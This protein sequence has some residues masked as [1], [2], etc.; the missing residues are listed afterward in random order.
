MPQPHHWPSILLAALVPELASA[1]ALHVGGF[2]TLGLSC[3]SSDQADFVLNVQPAGPGRSGRCDPRLDSLLAVQVDAQLTPVLEFGLQLTSDYNAD[4]DFAPEP[5]VAQLRWHI[6][7]AATLRLGRTHNP[8]FLYSESRNVRYAMPWVRPPLEV[9]GL[10]PTYTF[11]GAEILSQG[12]WQG[13]HMEFQGSAAVADIDNPRANA[14]GTDEAELKQAA[15]GLT[16]DQADMLF[17]ASYV[18]GRVSYSTPDLDALFGALRSLGGAAGASLASDLD[19]DDSRYDLFALAARYETDRWLVLAE[20]GYRPIDDSFFRDMQGAYITV[21]RNIG[22]WMPYATLAQ[23]WTH[24][25]DSDPRAG[26]F[27]PLVDTVLAATRFD[28]RSLS[29]GL[30]RPVHANATLKLQL[31]WIKPDDASWGLYTNHGSDYDYA[32]PDADYLM[33]INLDFVF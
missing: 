28:S 6:S 9:Y 32:H 21:G 2:G 10:L 26:A 30:S 4:G 25:P 22:V 33:S 7:D 18:R 24:G 5:T 20:Y 3:F 1:G 8:A 14:T 11:D 17:K 31:D 19:L 27:A 12:H 23:R 13:W 15:L 16:L 29:L